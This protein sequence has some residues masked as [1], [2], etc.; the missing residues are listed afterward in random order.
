MKIEKIELCRVKIPL[1]HYFETSF[2]RVY[3]EEHILVKIHSDGIFAYG[4]SSV[5]P[6][7]FYI[8]E[9]CDTVWH[10]Y[11]DF[12]IP[13]L[14]NKDFDDAGSLCEAM[15]PVR[16]HNFAKHG[17]E[18]AFLTLLSTKENKPF[19][20]LIGGTRTTI[21]SGVSIGIQDTIEELLDR[22]GGFLSE[23]YKRIKIKIKP[24]W[25]VNVV[26]RIRKEYPDV[27]LMVD[28]NSAYSL[29]DIAILKELDNYDLMMIEQPLHHDDLTE[30]AV[31]QSKI[32]TPVCLDE[33]IKT[34][35]AAQA[36]VKLGSCRIINIKPGRVGGITE[37]INIHDL[38][39]ENNIPVWCGG[40]LEFG[41]GRSINLAICTLD[42]F[43]IP[44]DV[45]SSSRYYT[46][47]ILTEPIELTN[48][49]FTMPEKPGTG[50][51]VN[52][53]VVKKYTVEKFST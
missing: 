48:G 36:A 37:T 6:D 30:H 13:S 12:L 11:R 34:L 4:E 51:T 46:E 52:E 38:C 31:L 10:I 17:L 32:D 20:K 16:G 3:D 39:K 7:P 1:K 15:A 33:S 27:P 47:D 2:G 22:V 19:F 25:D 9:T 43:T 42:N 28:A 41:I 40:M 21:N 5:A 23:G 45:S 24:G 26:E 50:F 35:S 18:S 14:I 29:N 8:Y 44:G 49:E 53:E